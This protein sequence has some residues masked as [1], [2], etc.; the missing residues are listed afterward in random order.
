MGLTTVE[1]VSGKTI[2]IQGSLASVVEA[3][4]DREHL[5]N[6]MI[7]FRLSPGD[8]RGSGA[9]YIAARHVVAVY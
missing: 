7:S 3:L 1:L 5:G 4:E 8:A 9:I 2:T 6:E